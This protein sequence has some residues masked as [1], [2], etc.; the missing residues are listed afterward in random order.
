M[1]IDLLRAKRRASDEI[2]RLAT[3]L[4][5]TTEGMAVLHYI[6]YQQA[7]EVKKDDKIAAPYVAAEAEATGLTKSQAAEVIIAASELFHLIRGP[8][9]EKIRR[10][11]KKAIN[12]ASTVALVQ[13]AYDQANNDL[14]ALN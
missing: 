5:H 7:L 4:W 6:K 3:R 1:N 13:A 8:T 9:I 14:T 11:G 2:D 12:A 10:V